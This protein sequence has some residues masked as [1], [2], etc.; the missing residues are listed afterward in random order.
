MSEPLIVA[1]YDNG[2]FQLPDEI[3]KRHSWGPGTRPSFEVISG[4]VVLRTA[5]T[6]ARNSEPEV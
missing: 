1:D 4:G 2:E 5:P 3:M 6:E